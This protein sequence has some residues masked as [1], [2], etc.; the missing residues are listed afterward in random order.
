MDSNSDCVEIT[1]TNDHVWV[2]NSN[3]PHGPVLRFT[4]DE[5]TAF[6]VGIQNGRFDC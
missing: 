4:S 5:W 2:R 3:N 6:L 1:H